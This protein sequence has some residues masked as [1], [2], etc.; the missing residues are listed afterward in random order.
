[1]SISW[2]EATASD[3]FVGFEEDIQ[4]EIVFKDW[5]LEEVE[6]FGKTSIEFSAIVTEEDGK[7]MTGL[8][9][10]KLLTTT[11][12]RLKKCLR[13]ILENKD[14]TSLVKITVLKIGD[15][16]DTQYSVKEVV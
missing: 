11:S 9:E 6:K 3:K 15:K 16:F 7:D 2:S 14:D 13:K 1:M 4:K 10:P 5:K 8:E 12:R